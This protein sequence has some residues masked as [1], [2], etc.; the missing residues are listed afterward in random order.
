MSNLV[1]VQDISNAYK[2]TIKG[3]GEIGAILTAEV[4]P[5]NAEVS[6]Q[7]KRQSVTDGPYEDIVGAVE[8]TYMVQN[9]ERY[10][11]VEVRDKF[12]QNA[13][14][15]SEYFRINK[16]DNI[17]YLELRPSEE[18]FKTNV[19]V[20][21]EPVLSD[22]ITYKYE[23]SNEAKTYNENLYT[24]KNYVDELK[25]LDK[26][27][28]CSSKGQDIELND[29]QISN[30]DNKVPQYLIVCKFKKVDDSNY[31]VLE[32]ANISIA[33]D[34]IK[35]PEKKEWE[36]K[37]SHILED[38]KIFI[39]G[40]FET[41][42]NFINNLEILSEGKDIKDDFDIELLLSNGRPLYLQNYIFQECYAYFVPKTR[43]GRYI[44]GTKRF[45]FNIIDVIEDL[46][47][48]EGKVVQVGDPLTAEVFIK[49]PNRGN[50]RLEELFY[51]ESYENL[52]F[53][54]YREENGI[55][56]EISGASG[57]RY[58]IKDED[59]GKTI[60]VEVRGDGESVSS[61]VRSS[62]GI[63][64]SKE[65]I[66]D[67]SIDGKA[68]EEDTTKIKIKIFDKD[69]PA[70]D[71]SM[72][73]AEASISGLLKNVKDE[74]KVISAENKE[75]ELRLKDVD[76]MYGNTIRLSIAGTRYNDTETYIH[77]DLEGVE[78]TGPSY[79]YGNTPPGEAHAKIKGSQLVIDGI[80]SV[81][82]IVKQISFQMHLRIND[83]NLEVYD[84]AGNLMTEDRFGETFKDGMKLKVSSKETYPNGEYKE[85]TVVIE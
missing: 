48:K 31:Q 14:I 1:F 43:E 81:A 4:E 12:S 49:V 76:K 36:I 20:T 17:L 30:L 27:L 50:V 52:I 59:V 64:I 16:R 40:R 15:E 82:D 85:Y 54:W 62:E 75:Y 6:Y 60:R 78:A 55:E 37:T 7:W 73:K 79:S 83:I 84:V 57:R 65:K 61:D 8:K 3:S 71:D 10:L 74:F 69:I 70:I 41:A 80:T 39:K 28:I 51:T 11:K 9:K 67:I 21:T 34:K 77:R 47:F 18:T 63:N 25:D 29:W 68:Y 2:V 19:R 45:D 72:V 33:K 38:D 35:L 46:R 22:E 53:R 26:D 42:E 66:L 32:Y 24:P 5:D 58:I 44:Y 23:I 13:P 56:E